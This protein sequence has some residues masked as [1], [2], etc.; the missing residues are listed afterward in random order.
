M[1]AKF[2]CHEFSGDGTY[3]RGDEIS[4]NAT[5]SSTDQG[6][7]GTQNLH[8]RHK[9]TDTMRDVNKWCWH[10][11]GY[12]YYTILYFGKRS[13]N[14]TRSRDYAFLARNAHVYIYI[15]IYI[16]IYLCPTRFIIYGRVL[17]IWQRR[18]VWRSV[19]AIVCQWCPNE[20][21]ISRLFPVLERKREKNRASITSIRIRYDYMDVHDIICISQLH[22]KETGRKEIRRRMQIHKFALEFSS[23]DRW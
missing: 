9:Q 10:F 12:W 16:Y 1:I 4:R 11:L 18:R 14:G 19:S 6:N 8:V 23:S 3:R 15:Y 20:N 13:H 21:E 22:E 7:A 17:G 5:D 2:L